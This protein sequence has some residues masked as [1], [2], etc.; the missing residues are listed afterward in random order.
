MRLCLGDSLRVDAHCLIHCERLRKRFAQHCDLRIDEV[1]V[2]DRD[3]QKQ[4][5]NLR[6]GRN[7]QQRKKNSDCVEIF[8]DAPTQRDAAQSEA[9]CQAQRGYRA[10]QHGK[11]DKRYDR[12]G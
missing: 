4:R 9:Q 1:R 11:Q 5:E 8:T 2:H 12:R 3:K 6:G 10:Y 7:D